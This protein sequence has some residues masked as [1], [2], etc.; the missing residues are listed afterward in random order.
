M[1]ELRFAL[2]ED[3]RDFDLLLS[4]SSP[5][6]SSSSSSSSSPS[7]WIFLGGRSKASRSWLRAYLALYC[8]MSVSTHVVSE[9]TT[10]L[11]LGSGLGLGLA[12]CEGRGHLLVDGGERARHDRREDE[13][14]RGGH[15]LRLRARVRLRA[16]PSPEP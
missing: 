8:V 7:N 9:V 3:D 14:A 6:P 5:V 13:H 10:W 12:S 15:L 16:R 1:D 4:L 11:G 2:V